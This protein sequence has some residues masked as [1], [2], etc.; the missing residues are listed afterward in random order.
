MPIQREEYL[1]RIACLA[2]LA[3]E[4][5][6]DG[7]VLSADSNVDY[8]AGFRHHSPWSLFARPFFELISADGRAALVTHTFLQAEMERTA[9]VRDIRTYARSGGAPIGLLAQT[10]KDLG[11]DSGRV[12]A[13]LGY[14]QRLGMSWQDF[15]ALQRALPRAEFVDCAPLLWSLRMKKSPAEIALIRQ[16]C[17]ITALT[18]TACFRAARAGMSEREV[19]RLAAETMLHLG[20][21]RPGFVVVSSGPENYHRLSGKPTDR[22]LQRGDMLW[23]DMGAVFDGYW[24]DFSRAGVVGGPSPEQRRMQAAILEVDRACLDAVKIGEP[25]KRIPMAAE[26]AMRRLGLD[27][28]IGEGRIGHG[29]GLMST[30]PPHV[31]HY[32]DTLMEAGMVITI[33]PRVL[34]SFGIF[35][36]EEIFVVGPAGPELLTSAPRELVTLGE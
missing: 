9:A 26:T 18:Y 25:V 36:V 14:E 19:C 29:L 31:A 17:E 13:E 30:E 3:R 22:K 12:G 33:E 6:L 21:E 23:M 11:V 34:A 4:Q 20:A 35:D 2:R 28:Q 24:S 1:Q 7:V 32:E 8:F 27:L 5:G 16:A 15:A 10:L